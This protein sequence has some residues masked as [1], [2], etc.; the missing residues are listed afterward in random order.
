M[1][2]SAA[3]I[4]FKQLAEEGSASSLFA[5]AT[6]YETGGMGLMSTMARL[7]NGISVQ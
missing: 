3:L 7:L 1:K 2:M 4:A 6:I 5:V